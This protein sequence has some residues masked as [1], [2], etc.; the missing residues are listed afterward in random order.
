MVVVEEEGGR[1]AELYGG[2]GE[3]E[4]REGEAQ[5]HRVVKLGERMFSDRHDA[6]GD[7]VCSPC[8]RNDTL[9]VHLSE[10]RF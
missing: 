10:R 3:E 4:H 5:G 1:E 2:G 7:T 6:P 9:G 8:V